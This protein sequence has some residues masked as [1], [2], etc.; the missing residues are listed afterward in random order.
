M[1]RLARFSYAL[2]AVIA[3]AA[4]PAFGQETGPSSSA[5]PYLVPVSSGVV[6]RSILTVGD[7]VNNK[8]DGSPYRMVGIPDGLGAYDNGNGTFTVLMN[9]ELPATAGVVRAHGQRG[10]FVSK[11]VID[12]GTLRVLSGEDLIQRT[13]LVSGSSALGRLCSADLPEPSAF[14]NQ[15]T[16]LGTTARILMNGEETGPE[17]RAFGHVVTGLSVGTT[18]ELPRLGKFSWE[19]SVANPLAQDKT[20]VIGT[21]DST[22]GQVY[23]YVGQKQATG[24]EVAR[25]GLTDGNLYG[26][27][28]NGMPVERRETGVGAPTRFSLANLGDVSAKTGAQLQT[29]SAAAGVTEFLRPEDGHWDPSNP[30]NFYFV[31][32]DRYD[33]VKDGVGSQIGRSRLYRLAFDDVTNPLSGGRIDMLLDGTEAGNMFDNLTIDKNGHVLLQED[34]GNQAHNGKIWSY[35]IAT[36][37]LSLVAKHDPSRFGDLIN[38]VAS[39]ARLPF[40]QDEESSGI[41]DVSH[42][43]GAGWF[44][45]DVQ[46]HYNIGDPELVEGGQLLAIHLTQAVPEP[47]SIALLASGGVVALCVLARRRRA[48]QAAGRAKD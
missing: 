1:K 38:G 21:D 16:G 19:N 15:A 13:V 30:N 34:V 42:I 47:S 32:T 8:P 3:M 22:P 26:I 11:Y 23:V 28:V 14:F 9:H 36:D 6:T 5:S 29:D 7:S 12:K 46:A 43:L 10:S 24:T 44:L 37:S 39:P 45:A 2:M 40:N 41:I 35:D 25:A 31:T 17:G 27:A 20:V 18:Y 48:A 4:G 33:Q